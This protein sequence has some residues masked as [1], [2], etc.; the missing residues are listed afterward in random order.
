MRSVGV[1]E[2]ERKE[3]TNQSI[4]TRGQI[5]NRLRNGN[6][7]LYKVRRGEIWIRGIDRGEDP[8]QGTEGS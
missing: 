1:G 8:I 2:R 3:Q 5:R 4:T 6:T 7:I